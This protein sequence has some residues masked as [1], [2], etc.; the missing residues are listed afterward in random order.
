MGYRSDVTAVFYVSKPEHLPVL[1]LWLS[2]NFPM[3]LFDEHIRWFGRGMILEEQ[4][5]KW[6]QDYDEIM[7][8][9]SFFL[10]YRKNAQLRQ[11]ESQKEMIALTIEMMKKLM[12]DGERKNESRKKA[13][14]VFYSGEYGW[15]YLLWGEY[16]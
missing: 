12:K 11:L 6:Y 14:G 15:T 7:R 10:R 4:N 8:V 5:I 16:S 1:K 9:I 3:D 2:E 13:N